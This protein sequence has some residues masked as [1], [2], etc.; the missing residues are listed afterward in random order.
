MKRSLLIAFAFGLVMAAATAMAGPDRSVVADPTFED[1]G[2]KWRGIA[3]SAST[4]TW[5]LISSAP[6]NAGLGISRW[7][8]RQV[9]NCSD[10]VLMLAPNATDFTVYSATKS[11]VL[12]SGSAGN[13]GDSWVVPSNGAVYG[14][15]AA[16]TTVTGG[17]CGSEHY[18]K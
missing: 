1:Y 4:Q 16:G 10:Q 11:V 17:A 15:W 13:P 12:K 14:I 8:F 5:V 2:N 6:E 9:T 3:V 7:R 18:Y